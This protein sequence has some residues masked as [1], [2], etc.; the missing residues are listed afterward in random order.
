MTFT[1]G[2]AVVTGAGSGLGRL[3]TISLADSGLAGRR[4]RA[5][6]RGPG[7]DGERGADGSVLPVAADVTRPG[8]RRRAVRGG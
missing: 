7:R 8:V 1:E 3:I 6:P 2:V 4:G 5:P